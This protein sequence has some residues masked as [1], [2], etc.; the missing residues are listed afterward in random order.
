MGAFYGNITLRGTTQAAAVEALRGYRAVVSPQLDDFVIV[1][2]Q[3]CDDQ[4]TDQVQ[5]LA[6]RLSDVLSCL[7]FAVLVHDDDILFYVCYDRG[8]LIDWYNS[9]P[10]YFDAEAT[11]PRPPVG[12]NAQVICT[13]F[14]AV[15]PEQVHL[16]LHEGDYVFETLRHEALVKTLAMPQV[17]VGTAMAT[18]ERGE[19]IEGLSLDKMSW[20]PDP[21]PKEDP[22]TRWDREFVEKLGAEDR[23]RLCQRAGCK[24][25]AISMGVLCRR[26]HF[27][28]IQGRPYPFES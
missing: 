14:G 27:E 11:E 12:G 25:G 26:H 20:A 1:Y 17:A 24:H 19:R 7:A 22:Q 15:D 10:D 16:I 5:E 13:V 2:S 6:A 28:M 9:A 4:N 3:C 21:P 23:F 8:E 18:F